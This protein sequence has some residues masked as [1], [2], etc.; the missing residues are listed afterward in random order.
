VEATG[1]VAH[2]NAVATWTKVKTLHTQQNSHIQ[3][4][5][6]TSLDLWNTTMGCSFHFKHRNPGALPIKSFVNDLDVP[7]YM[8]F[9][10]PSL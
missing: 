6:Q 4:N 7:W 10:C 2:Q 3:S 8:P 1:N 9:I 5:T